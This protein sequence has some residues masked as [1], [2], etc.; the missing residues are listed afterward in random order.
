MKVGTHVI[1]KNPEKLS[2]YDKLRLIEYIGQHGIIVEL[3]EESLYLVRFDVREDGSYRQQRFLLE[4]M[5]LD[6]KNNREE[7]LNK[8][9]NKK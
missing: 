1:I 5:E 4:E 9:L 6:I 7:R 2:F 3:L 8:L